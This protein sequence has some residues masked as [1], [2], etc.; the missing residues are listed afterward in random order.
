M[1]E[2]CSKR[3]VRAIGKVLHINSR[4]DEEWHL[5]V[6]KLLFWWFASI[7]WDN[8]DDVSTDFKPFFSLYILPHNSVGLTGCIPTVF[9]S[10]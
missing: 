5:F 8:N 4:S 2:I 1:V 7:T 9:F 10:S 3:L 6:T